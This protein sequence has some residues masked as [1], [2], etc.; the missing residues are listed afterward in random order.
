MK[1]TI[2]KA[3]ELKIG[4]VLIIKNKPVKVTGKWGLAFAL[5]MYIEDEVKATSYTMNRKLNLNAAQEFTVLTAEDS[6]SNKSL[7]NLTHLL[8]QKEA[9]C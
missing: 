6:N 2:K 8:N 1:T 5:D 4:D 9:I 7:F 3:T